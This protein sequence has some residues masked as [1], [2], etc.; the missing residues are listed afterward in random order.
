MKFITILVLGEGLRILILTL[1]IF[2]VHHV[3][4]REANDRRIAEIRIEKSRIDEIF[5]PAYL[6]AVF[7]V[8]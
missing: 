7:R 1:M 8:K 3:Y 2:R 5:K 6:T 4:C